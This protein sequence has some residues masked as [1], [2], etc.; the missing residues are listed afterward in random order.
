MDSVHWRE[1]DLDGTNLAIMTSESK[2][3]EDLDA[4]VCI[5]N[6]NS[7]H[8]SPIPRRKMTAAEFE[9][10]FGNSLRA[11]ME[12]IVN[13][14]VP[15]NPHFIE[16]KHPANNEAFLLLPSNNVQQAPA[17][18]PRTFGVHHLTVLTACQILTSETGFFVL[19]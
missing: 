13:P 11:H 5:P 14:D 19:V 17:G 3:W 8:H 12:D 15:F 18:E 6:S 10:V 1:W 2:Q 4:S 16:I 9:F 7:L